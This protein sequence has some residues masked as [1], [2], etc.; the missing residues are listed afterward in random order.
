[1]FRQCGEDKISSQEVNIE[2]AF[3]LGSEKRVCVQNSIASSP[4]FRYIR[5]K[6]AFERNLKKN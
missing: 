3:D 1:M 4:F 5:E 2:Q 6:V